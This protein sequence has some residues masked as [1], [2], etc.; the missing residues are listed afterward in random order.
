MFEAKTIEGIHLQ[1]LNHCVYKVLVR[2]DDGFYLIIESIHVTSDEDVFPG[3]KYLD[4]VLDEELSD[5]DS[6][7]SGNDSISVNDDKSDVDIQ[8]KSEHTNTDSDNN[9]EMN[10]KLIMLDGESS[11][12]SETDVNECGSEGNI[13]S[14]VGNNGT[15]NNSIDENNDNNNN[16]TD[17]D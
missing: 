13:S 15:E 9:S 4:E 1:T 2:H 5:N 3:A 11:Y 8:E 10:E 6:Y 7:G 16:D 14:N 12:N 17:Y